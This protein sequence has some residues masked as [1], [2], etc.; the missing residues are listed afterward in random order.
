MDQNFCSQ[1]VLEAEAEA[2]VQALKGEAEAYAIEVKAKV[3]HLSYL[4]INH[5][6]EV[7]A[8]MGSFLPLTY[9]SIEFKFSD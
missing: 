1:I 8:K 6:I 9:Y 5:V 2:E 4:M 3:G 7:K